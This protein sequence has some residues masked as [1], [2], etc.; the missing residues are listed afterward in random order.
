[1]RVLL[2]GADGFVG[3]HTREALIDAGHEVVCL[4]EPGRRSAPPSETAD[5]RSPDAVK[6]AVETIRPEGCIH[7][8]GIAFVPKGW[9]DPDLVFDVNTNGTLHLLEALR[10][11]APAC[12][13]VV[14]TSA[15]VY[16]RDPRPRPIRED[17]PTEPA[18]LY[19]VSKL[20]ADQMARLYAKRYNMQV[21]TAR[22]QN[23]IGPRQSADFVA[24]AFA[25]Q[26]LDIAAGRQPPHMRVGNL[27]STRDFSDV[28]DV[29][30]AYRLLTE[31]G[32]AGEA[33]NIAA[34]RQ[35]RIRDLFDLLCE[36][37]GTHPEVEIDPDRYRPTD[38]APDLDIGKIADHV[39]WQPRIPLRQTVQDLV[40]DCKQRT[41]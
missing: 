25:R 20:A 35:V 12:R 14:V 23:H 18:T 32:V 8:G 3:G 19:G 13:T 33:Y 40:E 37:A 24:V 9:S 22:P 4:V 30:R 41:A 6:H 28:R 17:D 29:A 1:M 7:L 31:A 16:G 21:M 2:T 27:D 11:H 34:G 15:E 38:A 39:G 5:L 36:C 26:L 10:T